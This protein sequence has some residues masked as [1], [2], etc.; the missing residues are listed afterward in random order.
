[1]GKFSNVVKDSKVLRGI[2]VALPFLSLTVG[3]EMAKAAPK[4]QIK[5]APANQ[6]GRN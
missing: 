5:E 1:M 3:A 2:L 4:L 6:N